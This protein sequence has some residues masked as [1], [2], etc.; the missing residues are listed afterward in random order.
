[1]SFLDKAK[2]LKAKAEAAFKANGG[3]QIVTDA[4]AAL[5]KTVA[6]AKKAAEQAGPAIEKAAGKID[7]AAK[8]VEEAEGKIDAAIQQG[9]E[10]AKKTIAKFLKK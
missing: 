7:A 5:D 2:E 9:A 3:E 10:Q 8:K 4:K 6:D 1:M